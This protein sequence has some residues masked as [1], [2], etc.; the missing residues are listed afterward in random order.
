MDPSFVKKAAW[1][2]NVLAPI[3]YAGLAV[4]LNKRNIVL[5]PLAGESVF[6]TLL[7]LVLCGGIGLFLWARAM[8][9]LDPVDRLWPTLI[10]LAVGESIS[11]LAVVYVL[12]GGSSEKAL[13]F[14]LLTL[15]YF[16]SFS[17]EELR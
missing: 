12:I 4:F 14:P 16:F 2:S 15:G 7:F 13:A 9:R 11:F 5:W 17:P 6:L 8:R 3:F 10:W 1:A